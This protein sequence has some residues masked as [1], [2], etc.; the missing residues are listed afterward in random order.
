M[1]NQI[2]S[3]L[4][5]K[6]YESFSVNGRTGSYIK[7]TD[8][9]IN[10][11][12]INAYQ[13]GTSYN[14]YERLIQT[15]RFNVVTQY[16]KNVNYLLLIVNRDGIFDDAL[17]DIASKIQGTWLMAADTGKIYIYENQPARFDDDLCEYLENNLFRL[18]HDSDD[19]IA[20][21]L[22][23]VNIILVVLNIVSFILVIVRSGN[24][25]ATYD[26]DIMLSMGALSYDSFMNGGWYEIITAI[27]LHF[28]ISH[29]FNNMLL[30]TYIGC[31]LERRIGAILYF[32]IYMGSGIVGNI[33]SLWYYSRLGEVTV[34]SAGASGAV[35]GV[36]GCLAMYLMISPSKN[37]NLT[38]KRL[39]IM[40]LLTIYYGLTSVGINNAAHIGGFCFGLFGGFLL[41]KILR[42]DKMSKAASIHACM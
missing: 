23:P 34:V 2:A 25:L 1:L 33:A 36:M 14:D 16:K 38:T 15:I 37:R 18:Q 39:I 6:G 11:I 10:L 9:D 22:T 19:T 31:E 3:L 12:I 17:T 29:L 27:F 41:S 5:Q 24:L 13:S 32:L 4:K 8:N 42:Y 40:A 28:G 26:S 20:Y 21:K 7:V 35:F 30:L